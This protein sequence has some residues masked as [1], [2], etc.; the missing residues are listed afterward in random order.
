[1]DRGG[2]R[3]VPHT[4]RLTLTHVHSHPWLCYMIRKE[5]DN[6]KAPRGEGR[7][8]SSATTLHCPLPRNPSGLEPAARSRASAH[9][10]HVGTKREE[11][12]KN[13]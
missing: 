9:H 7:I 12:E 1:M 2:V 11:R 13:V 8:F 5:W 6:G 4:E 10:C 3:E